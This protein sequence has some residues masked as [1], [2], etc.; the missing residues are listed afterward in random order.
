MRNTGSG[1][2]NLTSLQIGTIPIAQWL[3]V[4]SFPVEAFPRNHC[5][6]VV[7]GSG[8]APN[9]NECS[10]VRGEIQASTVFWTQ[11][12]FTV[13]YNGA[14]IQTCEASAGRCEVDVP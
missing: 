7:R 8:T 12:T 5:L 11:G 1:S 4:A 14:V 10:F 3:R 13:S 2:L 6:Q 9:T